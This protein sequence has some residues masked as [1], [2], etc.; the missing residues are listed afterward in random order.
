MLMIGQTHN[1]KICCPGCGLPTDRF[2][3]TVS[4][5]FVLECR[6]KECTYFGSIATV[7]RLTGEIIAVSLHQWKDSDGKAYRYAVEEVKP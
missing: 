1:W 4:Q 6:N 5:F 2:Q 3:A 7:E